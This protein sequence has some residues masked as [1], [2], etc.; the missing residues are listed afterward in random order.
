MCHLCINEHIDDDL[1]ELED[2]QEE[3]LPPPPINPLQ[4]SL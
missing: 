2:E 1:D 3:T 4:P